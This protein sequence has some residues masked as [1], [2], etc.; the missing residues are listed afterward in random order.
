MSTTVARPHLV[1]PPQLLAAAALREEL[2]ATDPCAR[3]PYLREFR[4]AYTEFDSVLTEP[5]LAAELLSADV[6]LVGDYHTLPA[7]QLYV[8]QLLEHLARESGREIVLGLEMV[9]A[10]DQ[11]WLD[12]WLRRELDE[13]ELRARIQYERS[14]GYEWAPFGALLH[15]GRSFCADVYGVDCVPRGDMRRIAQRDR[16]AA[17]KI[18][19][20]RER[21]PNAIVVIVFGEAHLAPN[22]L[23]AEVATRLPKARVVTVLQNI[24]ELYW[25]AGAERRGRAAVKVR[26]GVVCVFNAAPLEK[27]ESYRDYIEGWQDGRPHPSTTRRSGRSRKLRRTA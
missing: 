26:D 9:Y 4:E 1:R 11:K 8:A 18:A 3:H 23:P 21:H 27:Y 12:A 14:W 10:R 25:K 13:R 24:D 17:A 7:S 2:A 6:L 15:A 19:E 16:H 5:Q 22:H 20:L